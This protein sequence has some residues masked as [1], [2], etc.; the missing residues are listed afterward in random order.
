MLFISSA[1]LL[2]GTAFGLTGEEIINKVID[3]ETSN[4]T[5]AKIKMTLTD[6]KGTKRFR[7][8]V[9]YYK[10]YGKGSKSFIRF[11]S[12]PDVKGMGF[13]HWE[14]PGKDEQFIY[15]PEMKRTRRVAG[16]Q[17]KKSFPHFQK[18][19]KSQKKRK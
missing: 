16:G 15:L 19:K 18:Q 11:L 13:L 17:R 12:P 1:L 14:Q 2:P 10:K 4:T 6:K 5:Q 9:S 7:D 8:I 3:R